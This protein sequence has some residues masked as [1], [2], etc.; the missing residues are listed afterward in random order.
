MIYWNDLQASIQL[1]EQWLPVNGKFKNLVPQGWKSQLVF[2]IHW[3][4]EVDVNAS[5]GMNGCA[6]KARAE[7]QRE[8]AF[9]FYVL[10]QIFSRMYG[11]Y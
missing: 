4:P 7:R 5:E 9:F 8:K 11:L 3:I 1:T 6:S 10:I 2:C